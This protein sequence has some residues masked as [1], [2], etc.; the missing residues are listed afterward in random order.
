MTAKVKT[1]IYKEPFKTYADNYT[2]KFLIGAGILVR[3]AAAN[4]WNVVTG[5]GRNSVNYVTTDK[6]RSRFGSAP[7]KPGET[8]LPLTTLDA[9]DPPKKENTVKIGSNLIYAR[10]HER[11]VAWLSRAIDT[12][13]AGIKALAIRLKGE[14]K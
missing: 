7:G 8:A 5:R 11:K 10:K 13:I 3:N 12:T 4:K 14:F 1:I 2:E 6:K 9:L